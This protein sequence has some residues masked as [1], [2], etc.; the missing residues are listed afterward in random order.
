MLICGICWATAA[1]PDA[2][3][4]P[5]LIFYMPGRVKEKGKLQGT[6]YNV[7]Q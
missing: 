5:F 2:Q 6:K 1:L 7:S 4:G 3:P